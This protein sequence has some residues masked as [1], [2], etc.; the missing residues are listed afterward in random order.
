MEITLLQKEGKA[1]V[2]GRLVKTEYKCQKCRKY[3]IHEEPAH[4]LLVESRGGNFYILFEEGKMHFLDVEIPETPM[5]LHP[6]EIQV[7]HERLS[8]NYFRILEK[9]INM[10]ILQKEEFKNLLPSFVFSH[11]MKLYLVWRRERWYEFFHGDLVIYDIPCSFK[12]KIIFLD[13]EDLTF[14][15]IKSRFYIR[16][17]D[18]YYLLVGRHN[19]ETF[20]FS[21]DLA[22]QKTVIYHQRETPYRSFPVRGYEK[23]RD[24]IHSPCEI[25]HQRFK[26][27]LFFNFRLGDVIFVPVEWKDEVSHFQPAPISHKLKIING[28]IENDILRPEENQRILIYHPE[29]G[30]LVLEPNTYLIREVPY[31]RRGHD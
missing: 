8:K 17:D 24:I 21:F 9:M 22:N 28:K 20:Y 29:H 18:G 4:Y 1:E 13:K 3:C 30:T 25:Y 11:L 23:Y 16:K 5:N 6:V 2:K 7:L 12:R 26:P 10:N 19:Q 14:L 15:T 31:L 27:Y